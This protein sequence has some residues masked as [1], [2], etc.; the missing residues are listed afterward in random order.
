MINTFTRHVLFSDD[1]DDDK[2][3]SLSCEVDVDRLIFKSNLIGNY[4]FVGF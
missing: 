1:D 3:S 4:F 2:S